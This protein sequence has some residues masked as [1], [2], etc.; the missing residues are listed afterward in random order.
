MLKKKCVS[1][2][3]DFGQKLIDVKEF[4][5]KPDEPPFEDSNLLRSIAELTG[6][7]YY[8]IG[9]IFVRIICC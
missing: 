5:E 4:H 9:L 1:F 7:V 2:K 6:S 3:D 8:Y